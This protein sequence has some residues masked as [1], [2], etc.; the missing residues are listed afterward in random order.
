MTDFASIYQNAFHPTVALQ[1]PMDSM[2]KAMQMQGMMQQQQAQ[3]QQIQDA[4]DFRTQYGMSPG[5]AEAAHKVQLGKLEEE[6]SKVAATADRAKAV[7]WLAASN[8]RIYESALDRIEKDPAAAPLVHQ[9]TLK[10]TAQNAQQIGVDTS[11]SDDPTSFMPDPAKFQTSQAPFAPGQEGVPQVWDLE[12]QKQWL[13][14]KIKDT[15]PEAVAQKRQEMA[16][17]QQMEERLANAPK[18]E[19]ANFVASMNKSPDDPSVIKLWGQYHHPKAAASGEAGGAIGKVMSADDPQA[20]LAGLS[21]NDQAIVRQLAERKITLG[22]AGGF[23]LNKPENKALYALAVR[24]NPSLSVMDN[25]AAQKIITDLAGSSATSLGGRVDASNRMLGHAG[26]LIDAL[27]KLNPGSGTLGKVGNVLS[28]PGERLFG[29]TLAPVSFIKSKLLGEVNKLVTGGVPHAKE[30]EDDVK[31]MPDTATKEQW[32]AVIKSI[33]D[34][35][36]EQTN[37]ADEKRKNVLGTMAAQTPLLS[38]RAQKALAKVYKYAGAGA[39]ELVKPEGRGYTVS[40]EQ[41]NPKP[42]A[43]QTGAV[44]PKNGDISASGKYVWSDG[45]WRPRG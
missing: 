28:Y 5:M 10:G 26:D 18:G 16:L 27:D 11:K 17:K 32:G 13:R 21:P 19:I 7:D 25:A 14:Q 31:N 2:A 12:G 23:Q 6:K 42:A 15:T 45:K 43:Q 8:S 4:K 30:L 35:G 33:A 9:F 20:A 38:E 41:G 3:Q 1:D 24:L 29:A 37:A 34:V 22:R 44:D 40:A 39:P 36:L